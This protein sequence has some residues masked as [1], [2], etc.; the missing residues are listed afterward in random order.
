MTLRTYLRTLQQLAL[1]D[2]TLLDKTV[3]Y[4]VDDEGNRFNEVIF[5]PSTGHYD[6]DG[7]DGDNDEVNAV[8]IN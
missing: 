7:F 1:K 2:T 3:V 5:N 6:G 4:G 8:C